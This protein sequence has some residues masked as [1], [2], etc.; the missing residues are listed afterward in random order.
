MFL[1]KEKS[2]ELAFTEGAILAP[3]LKFTIPI[4]LALFLQ[5]LY[6]AVD[7][8][9]IGQFCDASSV[10]AV[11][12]G[13]QVM[14]TITGMVVGLTM[15]LTVLVGMRLGEGCPEDAG[16]AVGASICLFG[17]VALLITG[18]MLFGAETV[19]RLL[20]A[21]KEA[22][23]KTAQYIFICSAG[24]VFIVA[25][26]LIGSIFRGLGNSNL[27][28]LFVGIACL[29]NVAGDL[30]L[31]GFFHLDVTGAAL[32]T[33]VAQAGSVLIALTVIRKKKLPF[34]LDKQ[35]VVFR[36]SEIKQILKL[37]YPIALQDTLTNI[38]FLILFKIFNGLGVIVSAA[39]GVAE[40]I[41]IICMILPFAY[42]SSL[43]T[44]VAQNIG[45]QKPSRA[46]K[47]LFYGIETASVFGVIMF[48]LA[49]FYGDRL[50]GLFTGDMA[51]IAACANYLKAYGLDCICT[52]VLF[53]LMGY[54]TGCGRTFFVMLQGFCSAFL[55]RIPFSYFMSKVPGITLFKIGL[56]APLASLFSIILCV[57]Y[58]RYAR[59]NKWEHGLE[60]VSG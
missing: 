2:S 12:I 16:K 59:W 28:L 10:S 55:V 21:P 11:A 23:A 38:S 42:M 7:L 18:I 22:F 30:L 47:A 26:N 51:V 39:V 25:F 56:A 60:K 8:V 13:S 17:V 32:A 44:F 35:S 43:A 20:D 4:I 41:I 36:A 3:L 52:S 48:C 49:F 50:A 19:A 57:I 33:V 15:G 29:I 27:P 53:C 37:G 58:Y 45:A 54:F 1:P 9:V 46:K 6:G 31:V 34:R 5:S 40:K 24:S 14:Q